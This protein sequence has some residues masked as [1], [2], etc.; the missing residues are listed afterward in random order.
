M[1]RAVDYNLRSWSAAMESWNAAVS[2][3]WG[4]PTSQ[5]EG[6]RDRRFSAPEWEEH[7]YYRMLKET[8]LLASSSSPAVSSASRMRYSEA[9]R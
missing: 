8:Y 1:Q 4:L 6:R 9:S 7:P 3:A 5:R 2:R